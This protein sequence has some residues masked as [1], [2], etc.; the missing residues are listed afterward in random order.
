MPSNAKHSFSNVQEYSED[1]PENKEDTRSWKGQLDKNEKFESPKFESFCLSW[2]EP[3]EVGKPRAK[4]EGIERSW[5][6]LRK[7][8]SFPLV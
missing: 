2:K 3:S 7:L 1:K 5:K 8:E 6:F 4:S